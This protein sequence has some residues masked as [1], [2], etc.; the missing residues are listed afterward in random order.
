M[1]QVTSESPSAY[2]WVAARGE[3]W[4]AHVAP[5]EATLQP[6]NAPLIRALQ[7]GAPLRIAEVGCGGGSTAIEV[8]RRAP[9]GTVVHGLDI[10]PS[11]IELARSRVRPEERAIVFDVADMARAA[12]DEP[13]D[14]L[15]SRF[16]V[17]FF[18]DPTA[19]FA[20]LSRWLAPGGLF[21]F[22][23]WGPP[24]ENPWAAS[25]R[26]V[27][28]DILPLPEADPEAP[29]PFR[30]A[31]VTKLVALLETAGFGRLDVHD[32]RGALPI[33]G[34]LSPEQAAHFTLAAF[35]NFDELLAM[36]GDEALEEAR[37]SVTAA[38]SRHQRDGAVHMDACVRI[39][40]GTRL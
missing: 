18:D 3:K 8:L 1:R 40:T 37:R 17:M 27:V 31:D 19:A 30:Y 35:S 4:R 15:V 22:A 34:G 38:F 36:A 12:P 6:V 5:M 13:Y 24:A 21:A 25:V 11:L 29:G 20:N 33:G 10:S 28:A 26:D 7:L 9:E 16:G 2:D 39:V 14:R 23:V 32:W